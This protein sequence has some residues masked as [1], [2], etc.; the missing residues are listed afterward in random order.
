[1]QLV[2]VNVHDITEWFDA[3]KDYHI[4]LSRVIRECRAE[5]GGKMIWP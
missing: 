2:V 5:F 3:T 1:V 4:E